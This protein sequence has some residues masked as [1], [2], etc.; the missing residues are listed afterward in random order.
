MLR[1]LTLTAAL[2]TPIH[3]LALSCSSG[4][5]FMETLNSVTT[6]SEHAVVG[7][8]TF[9]GGSPSIVTP[10]QSQVQDYTFDGVLFDGNGTPKADQRDVAFSLSCISIWCGRP[11]GA[12]ANE[13]HIGAIAN[14][15]YIVVFSRSPETDQLSLHSGPCGSSVVLRSNILDLNVVSQCLL[16]GD[17][18]ETDLGL[19]HTR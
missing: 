5:D 11:L 17:C 18:S 3:A 19:T 6:F 8:G 12:I 10:G 7:Y 14:E 13:N 4:P 15:N 16:N 1:L 9:S 2:I